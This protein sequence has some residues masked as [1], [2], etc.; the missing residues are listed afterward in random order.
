MQ[1]NYPFISYLAVF[2]MRL[3]KCLNPSKVGGGD[4]VAIFVHEAFM[5]FLFHLG[6]NGP[7]ALQ[8]Y[9]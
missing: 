9:T 5:V 6:P 7:T 4:N 2:A 8:N 3:N 1:N